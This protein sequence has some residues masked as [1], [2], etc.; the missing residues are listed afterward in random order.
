MIQ[1]STYW[2][3]SLHRLAD[4]LERRS[5]QKRW[6]GRSEYLVERDIMLGAYSVRKLIESRKLSDDFAEE[7]IQVDRFPAIEEP[8]EVFAMDAGDWI[9]SYDF[10]QRAELQLGYRRICN[11]IIHSWAWCYTL[12]EEPQHLLTGVFVSSDFDKGK[13]LYWI[14]L[15][16]LIKM[17]RSAATDD[18]TYLTFEYTER[19]ERLTANARRTAQGE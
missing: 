8:R 4:E 16:D 5:Q 17:F 6:T 19:G 7:T 3:Q 18:I 2:K 10:N 1:D 13:W 9:D 12:T 14:A 15:D 11:Q